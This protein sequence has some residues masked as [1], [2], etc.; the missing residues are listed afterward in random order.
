MIPIVREF[1]R[2]LRE[3]DELDAIIPELLTAMGFEVLSRPMKGTRQYGADVAAIG[4]DDDGVR[5]LFLFA[6]KKG[7]LNREEWDGASPQSLRPSLN[8]IRDAYLS[9]LA[10]QH[11]DLPVVVCATIGGIVLENV[12]RQVNGYMQAESKGGI[13]FRLW[14][15]DTLTGKVVNGALREELFPPERRT[16]LRRAAALVEEPDA[17]LGQFTRLIGQITADETQDA[18]SRARILY[19]ALWIL[20]VWGREANNLEAPYRASE[21]VLLRAWELLWPDIEK[22]RGRQLTSSHTFFELFEL[23]RRIWEELYTGKILPHAAERHALSFAVRS[24]EPVDINLAMFDT[25]GRVAIGGLWRMWLAAPAS[26]APGLLAEPDPATESIAMALAKM[27]HANPALHTPISEDQGID[28]ALALTLLVMV[29]KA[30]KLAAHWVSQAANSIMINYRR[31]GQ[32]PIIESDY[33]ALIR[34]PVSNDDDYRREMT[35][36]SILYPTLAAF[37]WGF[38]NADLVESLGTFQSEDLS[39]S[40]FQVWVPNARSDELLWRGERNGS[41]LGGLKIGADGNELIESLKGEIDQNQAYGQL[42]AIRLDHAPMLLLACRCYRLPPPPQ[43]WLPLLE[44]LVAEQ[45]P[46]GRW[47]PGQPRPI[48]GF[49]RVRR[50]ALASCSLIP[51]LTGQTMAAETPP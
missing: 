25:L 47:A 18:P 24:Q 6:I 13:E 16:L 21:L 50:L 19:L 1:F 20:T 35:A 28:V 36:A 33:A 45:P 9:G 22:A 30:R 12:Q 26:T 38:G 40:N 3:R 27:V 34:H 44:E 51:L 7:D 14:T 41:G 29:P 5:K 4:V 39:H 15:G 49:A 31:K 46:L 23:H 32:Y 17:S 42:S 43:L 10:P 8:E 48:G 11:R 2:G 37:A